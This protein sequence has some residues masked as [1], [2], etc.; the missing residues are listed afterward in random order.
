[1]AEVNQRLAADLDWL[2]QVAH[3]LFLLS[4]DIFLSYLLVWFFRFFGWGLG[5][6]LNLAD[7]VA[8]VIQSEPWLCVCV[9]ILVRQSVHVVV[10]WKEQA[11]AHL[12][13]FDWRDIISHHVNDIKVGFIWEDHGTRLAYP[14]GSVK[15]SIIFHELDWNL[16]WGRERLVDPFVFAYLF[17]YQVQLATFGGIMIEMNLVNDEHVAIVDEDLSDFLGRV[18]EDKV[19]VLCY[20]DDPFL[21]VIKSELLGDNF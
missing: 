18:Q 12:L 17:A 6:L 14:D 20:L 16:L 15:V 1:M 19:G 5:P 4:L 9:R 8:D 21:V 13:E 10:I 7:A 11:R 2:K 3:Q